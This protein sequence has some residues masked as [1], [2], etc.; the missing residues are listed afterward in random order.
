MVASV[1]YMKAQDSAHLLDVYTPEITSVFITSRLEL[2][3]AVALCRDQSIDDPFDDLGTVYQQLEQMSIIGR[4]E[5]EKTCKVLVQ[6]FDETAQ[7]YQALTKSSSSSSSSNL[8]LVIKE[9]QLTWLVYIIGAVI[10][11]R[12]TLTTSNTEEHD[13][14]DGELVVRVLQLMT[15]I[16]SRLEQT[17]GHLA[18]EKLELAVLNFFEQ[19]RKIFVGDQVQK[20]SKVYKRMSEL[21]GIQDETMWLNLVAGKI[22]TNLKYWTSSERVIT[23]TLALL[24]DL[25][26]GYSSVRKL[27][28]LDCIHFILANHT[29][30]NFPF[31][32]FSS[33]LVVKLIKSRTIFYTALGR[34]LN[35][36]FNDDD[37]TFDR[38]IRPLSNQLDAIGNLMSQS[39]STASY[40]D[41]K[42]P[43]VGLARDLRGLAFAFNSKMAYMQFFEWLYPRY[44]PLFV[45]AVEVWYDEPFV[46]TPILK[47]MAELVQNRS[48]RLQFEISSPNGIL[49]FREAS[50]LVCTYGSRIL[51]LDT[52]SDSKSS[53]TSTSSFLSSLSTKAV[54]EHSQIYP[55]KL[56]GISICFN[57]L[58]WSLSG[59]YV[60][61]G[62][63]Q[64][65]NDTALSDSL[66]I[67]IKLL[68]SFQKSDLL[69]Y[70]KLS[71][72]YYG[73]LETLT[74]D[75]MAFVSMLEPQVF[76]YILGTIS[77]GLSSV[78]SVISTSCCTALDHM[79]SYLFKCLSKQ[80]RQQQQQLVPLIQVYQREPTVF[81]QLMTTLINIIIFEDCRNQWSMSRPLL[82]LILLNED[83]KLKLKLLFMFYS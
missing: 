2:V 3:N 79:I 77:D 15:Y 1:P 64:L 13:M 8:D 63:F 54:K 52:S 60:N 30:E 31:L 80:K 43:L 37:D 9:G 38:F 12:M 14:Y 75:H 22:I 11:G 50:R 72:A 40:N 5:Y 66:E 6:L 59:G 29:S 61:F 25:S 4:C 21:L 24:N 83:V 34:L 62:I 41:I 16:N 33:Q 7:Q 44:L 28:K 71:L 82:G 17:S 45:K 51:S 49:L 58:K 26:F 46:T 48:Q 53:S 57:I 70:S 19:F 78:D 73:L 47:L 27:M 18:C 56:K 55:L 35:L 20:S 42:L 74:A 39:T 10:G 65:Y 67:F 23:K 81:H 76:L 68:L 36:D 32:G 69:V